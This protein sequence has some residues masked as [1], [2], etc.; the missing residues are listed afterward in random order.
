MLD[1][2]VGTLSDCEPGAAER[3]RVRCSTHPTVDGEG[4]PVFWDA[5]FSIN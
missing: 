2:R 5:P 1:L 4:D 3:Y